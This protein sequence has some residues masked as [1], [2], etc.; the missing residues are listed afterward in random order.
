MDK[1]IIDQIE[2]KLSEEKPGMSAQG[3]MSPVESKLYLKPSDS[4][5]VASVM[6][7]LVPVE[8]RWNVIYIKRADDN[9]TDKHAGQISLPGG[10]ME[11]IDESYE[12]CAIRETYEEIGI[13]PE[14]IKV[15][16]ELSPLY[17]YVSN[18]QVYPYVGYL[19]SDTK[20]RI[21]ESEV[22]E[23]IM[24]PLED[25]REEKRVMNGSV[26]IFNGN[27]MDVP[28]YDLYGNKLWGATAMITAEFLNIISD[29]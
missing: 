15:I 26:K 14:K 6:L 21:Q 9:P 29:I 10:K 1:S 28:Y 3:V 25:L 5:S 27:T 22:K 7:L 12:A 24:I 2:R 11:E 23:V 17:V 4:A 19:T 18:F 13:A 8:G 20:L 16:G